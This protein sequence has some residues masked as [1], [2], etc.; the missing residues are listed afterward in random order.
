MTNLRGC[1]MAGN[2]ARQ[3]PLRPDDAELVALWISEDSP[4]L[5]APL[6][7]VDGSRPEGD[8]ALDLRFTFAGTGVD[9]RIEAEMHTVLDDLVVGY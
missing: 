3:R 8:E 7:D 2:S 9:A 1:R 4:R 6:T 5:V